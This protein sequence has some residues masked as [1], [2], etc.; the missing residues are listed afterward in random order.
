MITAAEIS[1]DMTDVDVQES[2][3]R[4]PT[5]GTY[6]AEVASVEVAKSKKGNP[7]LVIDWRITEGEFEGV[8][9]RDW[10][11][12]LYPSKKQPGKFEW[13]FSYRDLAKAA[14]YWPSSITE[15][16][17]LYN[18]DKFGESVLA[19]A[20]HLV[21]QAAAITIEVEPGQEYEVKDD[22]GIP[23]G[24]TRIGRDRARVA[25]FRV[26]EAPAAGEAVALGGGV[27]FDL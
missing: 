9:V 12:V 19:V 16:N 27:S 26:Q 22:M 18:K 14:G 13:S 6:Q 21:G 8:S 1:F 15:R 17:K 5:A 2:E 25:S 7:M 3:Y 11:V 24:E 10:C 20:D 23:T 4:T